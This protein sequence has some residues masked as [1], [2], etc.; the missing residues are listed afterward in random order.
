MRPTFV[1]LARRHGAPTIAQLA[2]ACGLSERA[3]FLLQARADP[4]AL[5][6]AEL[7]LGD[8]R[9]RNWATPPRPGRPVGW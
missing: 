3:I 8:R 7:C 9:L 2:D 4:T 1:A 5:R 6:A